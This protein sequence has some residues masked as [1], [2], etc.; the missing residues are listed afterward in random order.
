MSM[1]PFRN[2]FKEFKGNHSIFVETGTCKGDSIELANQAGYKRILS[3]DIDGANVAHCQE[4]FQLIP[5][6]KQ[7]AKNSHI[8]IICG[9]SATGLLKFM[10]YVNEPAMIWLDAHSQLFD[11]EPPTENPFPLLIELEQLKKH[12]IKTHTILIDDILILTHPDVT[13]WTRDTIENA[14]LM[15]N[16]AYKLTYLSNPVVNNILMAHV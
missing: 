4:R 16:P 11:D 2:Y 8:N 3:M 1:H 6:D 12:P 13:G 15:I 14:L 10:K 9:D 5:D 7:P